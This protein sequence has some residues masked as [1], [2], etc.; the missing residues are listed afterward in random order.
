MYDNYPYEY[1]QPPPEL[2]IHPNS[3]VVQLGLTQE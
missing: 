2:D 1:T 3:A